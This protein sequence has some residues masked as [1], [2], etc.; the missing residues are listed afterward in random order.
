MGPWT[1]EFP[2]PLL[3]LPRFEFLLEAFWDI[4]VKHNVLIFPFTK[5]FSGTH[6]AERAEPPELTKSVGQAQSDSLQ[7]FDQ[8]IVVQGTM[9]LRLLRRRA[10]GAVVQDDGRSVPI[11]R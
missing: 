10:L 2:R 11:H 5:K 9:K 7:H 4:V 6:S 3:S 1:I 8:H